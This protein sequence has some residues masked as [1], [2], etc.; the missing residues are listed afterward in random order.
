MQLVE[1]AEAA[2]GRSTGSRTWIV[3]DRPA[4]PAAEE[5]PDLADYLIDVIDQLSRDRVLPKYAFERR[6]DAFISPFLPEL[7][8]NELGGTFHFIAS[9]FPLKKPDGAQSVNVDALLFQDG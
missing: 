8:A 3:P 7:L 5:W 4:R 1:K 6:F 2:A 9:E